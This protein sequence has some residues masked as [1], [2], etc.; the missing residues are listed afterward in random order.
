MS[1]LFLLAPPYWGAEDWQVSEYTLHDNFASK[2]SR[3][4]PV[5]FYHS[6]DDEWV[7]FA[8]LALY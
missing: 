4:L 8:H 5:F 7:P 6:R 1:G 3:E 2:L